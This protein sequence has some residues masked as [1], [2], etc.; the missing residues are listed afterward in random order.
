MRRMPSN[1]AS[2]RVR[3][4]YGLGSFCTGT[5]GAVPGLLLLY[6]LTNIPGVRKV[7]AGAA[8]FVPKAWDQFIAF[9][10]SIVMTAR[11][12]LTAGRLAHPRA[13][14]AVP[15]TESELA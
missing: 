6:Y 9:A 1:Q 8:V 13:T 11:Y 3:F 7:I 2:R 4:G 12:D 15:E 14:S 5:F 10:T